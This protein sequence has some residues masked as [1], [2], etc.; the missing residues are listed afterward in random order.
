MWMIM[1]SCLYVRGSKG[2][3]ADVNAEEKPVRELE[4]IKVFESEG[5][6]LMFNRMGED[7][8]ANGGMGREVC[9][10]QS[11]GTD[12]LRTTWRGYDWEKIY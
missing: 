1:E 6:Q 11:Q 3:E 2:V 5:K 12:H 9:D 8:R 7:R 10:G 4:V